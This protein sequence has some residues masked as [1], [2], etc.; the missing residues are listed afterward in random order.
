MRKSADIIVAL[1]VPSIAE[2]KRLVEELGDSIN[3]YKVGM[4]LF[5]SAGPEALQMVRSTGKNIFLDLKLHDIPNTVAQGAK[6]LT[7]LGADFI[8]IHSVGGTGMMQETARAVAA[9]AAAQGVSRP[10]LLAI[11]VLTSIGE[12]DWQELRY[13]GVIADQVVHLAKL[14]QQA[15]IDGVVAS[16]QEAGNIRRACGDNFL[17]VTP[18]V[19]PAGS[20]INDQSRIATPAGAV[21]AGANYLVIGR[22]ITASADP[23]AAAEAIRQEMEACS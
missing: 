22:P 6:A 18:G 15:G 8:S 1:D 19:R 13:S 23:R 10:K 16:P 9:A 2:A 11:T 5:Y 12:A 4:E 7:T 17:I 3:T 14:A 21:K 20:A